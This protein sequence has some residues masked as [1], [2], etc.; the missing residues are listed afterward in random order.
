[1][2][3]VA[4]LEVPRAHGFLNPVAVLRLH[5]GTTR[6]VAGRDGRRLVREE[7]PMLRIARGERADRAP[8]VETPIDL[9]SAVPAKRARYGTQ[10]V[11][12]IGAKQCV[13]FF[14]HDLKMR[15][16]SVGV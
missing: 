4:T 6:S 2:T 15:R 13:L 14:G 12:S 10:H 16:C 1:M 9:P 11:C 5:A 3:V 7:D 8:A